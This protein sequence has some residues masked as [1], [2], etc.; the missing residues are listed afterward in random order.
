MVRVPKKP[1]S[2]RLTDEA[3]LDLEALS[4]HYRRSKTWIVNRLIRRARRKLV[5]ARD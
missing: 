1:R 3:I 4:K 5:E 2:F